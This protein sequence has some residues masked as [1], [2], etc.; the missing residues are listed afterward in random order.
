MV[1]DASAA[2]VV[3][4][5]QLVDRLPGH[6]ARVVRL[7]ADWEE[8]A[9][10]TAPANRTIPGNLAYVLYTSGSTGKPK[11]VSLQHASAVA[12]LSWA[13]R[14]FSREDTA[15]TIASTSICFDL[16]VFELFVPLST[17]GQVIV[18]NSAID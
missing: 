4:Q 13:G 9:E 10:Q 3:T 17:G 7:D 12:M 18:A 15:S 2:V 14:T 8:I 16:S 5:A 1:A 6:E 11:G